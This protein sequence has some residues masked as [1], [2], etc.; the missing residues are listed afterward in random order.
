MGRWIRRPCVVCERFLFWSKCVKCNF[1]FDWFIESL[2][3]ADTDSTAAIACSGFV[4]GF[5]F[6]REK[7]VRVSL[8]LRRFYKPAS[9]TLSLDLAFS[10]RW[11]APLVPTGLLVWNTVGWT[12]LELALLWRQ[13][14]TRNNRGICIKVWNWTD[15]KFKNGMEAFRSERIWFTDGGLLWLLTA[16]QQGC[17]CDDWL[18]VCEGRPPPSSA[19]F[20]K[21]TTQKNIWKA[22]CVFL[23]LM[24]Q[25]LTAPAATSVSISWNK[26]TFSN[27]WGPSALL[28]YALLIG[29]QGEAVSSVI[30]LTDLLLPL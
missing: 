8:P 1:P 27:I 28:V 10:S 12:S 2:W 23:K 13:A 5:F 14:V 30:Q 20:I 3:L 24:K 17:R 18:A 15:T 16:A 26:H 11:A 29:L 9:S 22:N 25:T 6:M 4:S 19:A 7:Q 21:W